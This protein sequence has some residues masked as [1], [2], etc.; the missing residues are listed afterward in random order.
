MPPAI[1][2]ANLRNDCPID[3]DGPYRPAGLGSGT[4]KADVSP[5]WLRDGRTRLVLRLYVDL[6]PEESYVFAVNPR[7]APIRG[8]G[9][10]VK[11]HMSAPASLGRGWNQSR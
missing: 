5:R 7:P 9:Q 10:L 11:V 4:V 1:A 3:I 2:T 6:Q 8:I